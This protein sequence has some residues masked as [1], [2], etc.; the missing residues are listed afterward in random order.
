[1]NVYSLKVYVVVVGAPRYEYESWHANE[2]CVDPDVAASLLDHWK[3]D[4]GRKDS[5]IYEDYIMCPVV[6]GCVVV[7]HAK[8]A[9]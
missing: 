3:G 5:F 1:M 4:Q 9:S 6:D 7:A 8:R 2:V